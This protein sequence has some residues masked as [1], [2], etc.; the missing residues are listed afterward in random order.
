MAILQLDI[1]ENRPDGQAA[2]ERG[3]LTNRQRNWLLRQLEDSDQPN[4]PRATNGAL[5]AGFLFVII[6][7]I[8]N[9]LQY[10][11]LADYRQLEIIALGVLL[12]LYL[13]IALSGRTRLHHRTQVRPPLQTA[14]QRLA[15]GDYQIESWI[16]PVRFVI[17][18]PGAYRVGDVESARDTYVIETH[19]HHFAVSKALWETL[20][21]YAENDFTLHYLTEPVVMLLSIVHIPRSEPPTDAELASVIGISDD[22]ELIYE[23]QDGEARHQL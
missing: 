13:A 5:V 14:R 15:N 2:N 4:V 10:P 21:P 23:E 19:L 16:G 7:L 18:P 9:T 17:Y 11:R 6:G 22:G 1:T 20:R 8:W 12:Y 3:E